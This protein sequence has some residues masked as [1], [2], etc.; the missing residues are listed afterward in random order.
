MTRA[1]WSVCAAKEPHTLILSNN[2]NGREQGLDEMSF[3]LVLKEP[4]N[5]MDRGV[6]LLESPAEFHEMTRKMEVLY[7]QEYLP[8]DEDLRV[9]FVGDGIAAAYW[10]R[11]GGFHHNIANGARADFQAIP[12][13]ALGLVESVARGIRLGP[14]IVEYLQNRLAIP[15]AGSLLTA[16]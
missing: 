8:I 12:E 4:L 1:F 15:S 14:R 7:V 5:S 9:V 13:A 6:F 3:P 2:P 16:S 10:K 11:G